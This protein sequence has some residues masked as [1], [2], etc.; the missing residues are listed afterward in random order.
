MGDFAVNYNNLYTNFKPVQAP[1]QVEYKQ[2]GSIENVKN[3]FTA[4]AAKTQTAS[5]DPYAQYDYAPPVY[6]GGMNVGGGHKAGLKL[7]CIG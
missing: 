4:G 7:D 6:E 2:P 5:A 3:I 1:Q